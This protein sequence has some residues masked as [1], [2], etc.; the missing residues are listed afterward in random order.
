MRRRAAAVSPLVPADVPV[1]V[2]EAS[3]VN[4]VLG[5]RF[6]SGV[7]AVSRRKPA[8]SVDQLADAWRGEEPVTLV[9]CPE[10][11]NTDNM[12][13]LIR[14]ASAFGATGMVLGERCCDPF[15]RQSVRVSM[16]T[17]FR[18]PLVRSTDLMDDL[19]RLRERWGVQ[20][21]GTVCDGDA[22]PLAGA[23]RPERIGILFGNE[24]QGLSPEH[25]AACDR[26]V[27]IPMRLGTDSLNVSV[28]AGVVL[29][30][31]TQYAVAGAGRASGS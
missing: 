5:Y 16:G 23:S 25:L 21:I 29:Y 14:I 22:E 27:T 31:F 20:L 3:V 26:R 11:S 12:G 1:Y 30:H 17:I 2:A 28:A 4:G 9:V 10:V 13:S 24:A 15:Y 18:M 19:R 8:V 6:H 7:M